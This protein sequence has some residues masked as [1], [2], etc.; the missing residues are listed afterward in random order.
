MKINTKKVLAVLTSTFI[1]TTM[2]SCTVKN[3]KNDID[4]TLSIENEID[5]KEQFISEYKELIVYLDNIPTYL[6]DNASFQ[7]DD[8]GELISFCIEIPITENETKTYKIGKDYFEF[9]NI[10][11]TN[12]TIKK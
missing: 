9:F 8:N 12:K 7:Y 2:S 5:I 10:P 1:L 4:N 6:E 11:D 3:E